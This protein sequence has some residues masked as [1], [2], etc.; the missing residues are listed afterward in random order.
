MLELNSV[1]FTYDPHTKFKKEALKNIN[2]KINAGEKIAIV[3]RIGSGKSTLI[4]IMAGLLKP[5]SG[6][7]I[8]DS[9][10][11][12][13]DK[14]PRK[15]I[16]KKIGVVFQYPE[17]QFFAETVFEEIAYGPRNLQELPEKVKE[18]VEKAI[19]DVGLDESYLEKS[20]FELSGGEKRRV[21]IASIVSM[22][23]TYLI[24]DEPTSNLDYLGKENIL[25]YL[26]NKIS[27]NRTVIFVSHNMDEVL[28]VSNRIIALKEGN[29]IF[30]GNTFDF[31][32]NE[33]LVESAGLDVPFPFLVSK[34]LKQCFSDFPDCAS[35]DEI[36]KELKKRKHG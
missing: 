31:F 24:L 15:E 5:T 36:V 25:Y 3:G 1:S 35:I 12:T 16:V 21:A 22:N 33:D 30:D 7:V 14:V 10:N 32:S 17:E 26:K 9:L 6:E 18:M 11:I 23:P 27:V 4:E 19:Q 34:K 28:E 13:K 2:L 20:P 29:I 8:I